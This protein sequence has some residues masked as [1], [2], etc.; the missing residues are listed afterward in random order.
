MTEST[1]PRTRRNRPAPKSETPQAPAPTQQPIIAPETIS[2]ILDWLSTVD[3]WSIA[4]HR[5]MF[6]RWVY[7]V[8]ALF[9][10]S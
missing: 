5:N 7:V 2:A 3:T 10:L 6:P 1:A 9:L 8:L 4:G